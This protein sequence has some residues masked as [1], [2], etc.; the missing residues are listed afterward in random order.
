MGRMLPAADISTHTTA[1]AGRNLAA[2]GGGSARSYPG[3]A[4]SNLTIDIFLI[5][6]GQLKKGA[7]I[8]GVEAGRSKGAIRLRSISSKLRRVDFFLHTKEVWKAA[9]S[10][11]RL[12]LLVNVR[13]RFA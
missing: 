8:A 4:Q 11:V 13:L 10:A 7:T 5:K 3:R 2:I 12:G 9:N 1:A 6:R